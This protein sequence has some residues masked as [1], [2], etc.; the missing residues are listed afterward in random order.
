MVAITVAVTSMVAVT[1]AV[2]SMVA[3]TVMV[4]VIAWWE[5]SNLNTFDYPLIHFPHALRTEFSSEM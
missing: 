3:V 1:V 5:K 4:A 2:T